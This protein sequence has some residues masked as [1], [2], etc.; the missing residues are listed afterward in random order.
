M[1]MR[2]E[3]KEREEARLQGKIEKLDEERKRLEEK[4][5]R[6][7]DDLKK[8]LKKKD[9]ELKRSSG[10]SSKEQEAERGKL[11]E[12]YKRVVT[13]LK[14]QLQIR[15]KENTHIKKLNVDSQDALRR[16]ER[17]MVSAFHELGLRYHQLKLVNEQLQ[18][19]VEDLKVA[20]KAPAQAA[21]K[22]KQQVRR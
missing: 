11:E 14:D 12:Q 5:R 17:V 7:E 6:R 18:D 2:M 13:H 22:A 8:D 4:F 15:E 19:E 21:P 10:K 9:E 16:E 1:K 20:K 3:Q